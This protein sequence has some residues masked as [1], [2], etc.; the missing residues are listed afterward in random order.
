MG[1]RRM[2][3]QECKQGQVWHWNIGG[4][5][6]DVDEF[7]LLLSPGDARGVTWAHLQYAHEEYVNLW[8]ALNLLT[9][10]VELITPFFTA[11]A[12]ELMD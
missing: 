9:G 8:L 3:L 6:Y 1:A 7:Y 5:F 4:T 10:E 11:G 2:M 12:W